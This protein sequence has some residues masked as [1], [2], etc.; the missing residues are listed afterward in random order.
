MSS[1][2]ELSKVNIQLPCD[3]M[4]HSQHANAMLNYQV[5]NLQSR[6]KPGQRRALFTHYRQAGPI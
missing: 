3:A 5:Y 6:I 2:C 1:L 4:K